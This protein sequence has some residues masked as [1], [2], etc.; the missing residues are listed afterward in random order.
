MLYRGPK[1]Y[2]KT[3]ADSIFIAG[4][5]TRDLAAPSVVADVVVLL[6][7]PESPAK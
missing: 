6:S 2:C 1:Q 5:S 3:N 7:T 4:L